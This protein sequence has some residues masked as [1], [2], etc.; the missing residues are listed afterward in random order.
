ML[1]TCNLSERHDGIKICLEVGALISPIDSVRA[2]NLCAAIE[3]EL[4]AMQ[5]GVDIFFFEPGSVEVM[6]CR[7][8]NSKCDVRR[9]AYGP[10]SFA[11]AVG[12]MKK[13][14]DV[15]TCPNAEKKWHSRTGKLATK[16]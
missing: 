16:R 11:M 9:N 8:C 6:Y 7:I 4:N 12:K 15:F 3:K 14:H 2:G 1:K 13:H 5:N 10:A